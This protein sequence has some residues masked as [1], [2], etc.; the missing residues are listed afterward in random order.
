MAEC[1]AVT[2][3]MPL[4]LTESLDASRRELTHQHIESCAVCSEEWNAYR[5]TWA[6]M[7]DLP[8]VEVP[9]RVKQAFLARVG[10]AERVP[11]NVVPFHRKPAFK[12]VAQAAAVAV[13]VGGAYFAGT[14]STPDVEPTKASITS[15]QP[16]DIT[17][18]ASRDS[19]SLAETRVMDAGTLSPEI[20]GRPNISN[21]QFLDDDAS[22]D[23][24]AVS[25]DVTSRW[26]VNGNPR[27]KSMVRLL[28]YMLENDTAI[29]PRSNALEWVRQTYSDPAYADPEIANALAKVLRN[30]AHQ[31]VRIRAIETLTTLPP[32]VA[33]ETRD[34]LIDALKSDPNP[35]VRI[36]AVEALANMTR[37]GTVL[38]PSMVDTLRQKASQDDE[39]LYVRVKAAEAL[40]NIKP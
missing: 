28:A 7:G 14:T 34:A 39:N 31:G 1:S 21:L 11:D 27:E 19:Y 6:V 8:E 26:T 30:D 20:Q 32:Q 36:K 33:A 40:S 12:W 9:A 3:S 15:I 38:D 2:E 18:V 22:D 29:T 23:Q 16:N 5:E 4:L 17:R 25:F 13:L 24:I 37:A 10:V 35:A